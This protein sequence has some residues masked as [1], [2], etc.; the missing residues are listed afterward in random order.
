M[1]HVVAEAFDERLPAMVLRQRLFGR[2]LTGCV[3]LLPVARYLYRE[4]I[5]WPAIVGTGIALTGS[6][7]L[8]FI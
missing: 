2:L 1:L 3:L 8:F 7:M 6:A 5:T 4:T